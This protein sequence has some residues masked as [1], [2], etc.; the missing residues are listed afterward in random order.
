MGEVGWKYVPAGA[1][2]PD[3]EEY[4]PSRKASPGTLHSHASYALHKAG[5]EGEVKTRLYSA[6]QSAH[7]GAGP[8]GP[9]I[10]VPSF[11]L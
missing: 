11:F 7:R 5:V 6:Y 1:R 3:A 2:R 10:D 4:W 8:I 9:D